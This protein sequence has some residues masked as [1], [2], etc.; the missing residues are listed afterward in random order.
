MRPTLPADFAD[1][2]RDIVRQIPPGSVATYGDIARLAGAPR[3]ARLVGR[4]L[5]ATPPQAQ[6]PC[7]RVVNAAGRTA[8]GWA[9]QQELLEAEGVRFRTEGRADLARCGWREIRE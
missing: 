1:E 8:P 4:I 7:H 3:H 2:V 5:A 9:E 6:V